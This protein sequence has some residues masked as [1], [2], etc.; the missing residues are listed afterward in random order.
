MLK[1][2]SCRTRG[3]LMALEQS[4][5]FR[6]RY[7]L[8]VYIAARHQESEAFHLP[9]YCLLDGTPVDFEVDW[10][11]STQKLGVDWLS[12]D[13]ETRKLRIPNWRERL[14]CPRCGL[15]NR[16]RAIAAALLATAR[17]L[18][19]VSGRPPRIYMMEQVTPT[20]HF[21]TG[22]Q[23]AFEL[24]GS[25]FLDPALPGGTVRDGIRHE[26]AEA[27]SF[28]DAEMD[29]V[30][31]SSVLEH[32]D[33][34]QTAVRELARV[35]RP[36]GELFL[37]VPFDVNKERNTRRARL[38]D[39]E[40]VHLAPPA[41]HG[42]PLSDDGV[43]VFNDFGWELLDQIRDTG[44]LVCEMEVYWSLEHGHLGGAQFFS[45]GRGTAAR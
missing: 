41:Y 10:L 42:D 11:Y 28:D 24:V 7:A 18:R 32:V 30:L 36:G 39:G 23:E 22:R 26:N 21:F 15:N 43:L 44:L 35:L 12:D 34:P 2:H 33:Q 40:I 5:I 45:H 14:I 38:E 37:E 9:G 29:L 6:S 4:E 27:L 13:G 19:A 3:E 8:E 25:E 17:R 31:C 1:T 20:Y 16:Q